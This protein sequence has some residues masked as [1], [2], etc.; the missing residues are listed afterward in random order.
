MI[1]QSGFLWLW[2][3]VHET[4]FSPITNPVTFF[5][6]KRNGEPE[7]ILSRIPSQQ[8]SSSSTTST[9]KS[10]A[11]SDNVVDVTEE[12]AKKQQQSNH[13]FYGNAPVLEYRLTDGSSGAVEQKT[14]R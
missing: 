5:L 14:P 3:R 1:P 9:P 12:E 13:F 11:V 10:P 4:I 6:K 7:K 2:G 8:T